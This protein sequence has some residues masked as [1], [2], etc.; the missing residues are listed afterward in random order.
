MRFQSRRSILAAAPL[1]LSL[2]I[3][4]SAASGANPE[5]PDT[6]GDVGSSSS[7]VLDADGNPVVS[8]S[9]STN[10]DLKVLHCND[11]NC[12]GGDES[13][14]SPDTTGNDGYYTSLELDAVGNP[15]ISYLGGAVDLKVMHCNDPNCAGGDESIVS[16]DTVGN[17][18]YY[19][20]LELDADGN[21]VVSYYD[22]TNGNLKVLH[23]NDPDCVGGDSIAIA[24]SGGNFGADVVGTHTSLALDATGKPVISYHD[25]TNGDLKVVHCDDPACQDGQSQNA[26]RA[27]TAD[28]VG[29]Y[30]SLELD[31]DGNPVVS[32][33]D[34][35]NGDLKLLHCYDPACATGGTV[36]RVDLIDRVGLWTSLALDGAGKPVISYFDA[37]N[38]AL[39]VV[40]CD[41]ASCADGQLDE[42]VDNAGDV[43]SWSSLVLDTDGNPVISYY[44]ATNDLNGDLKALHCDNPTCAAS[45]PVTDIDGDGIP[46]NLDSDA[47][48]GSA[49]P[50]FSDMSTT[51]PTTATVLSGSVTVVDASDPAK[52]VRVTAGPGGAVLSPVCGSSTAV[53]FEPSDS[54]T[55][56]C[57]SIEIQDVS[58][59]P[60]AV[61]VSGGAVVTFPDGT[62]GTVDSTP[63]GSAVVTGVS[64]DGVTLT[65]GGLTTPVAEGGS[66]NLIVG[67][68]GNNT[69]NGTAG[70]DMIVGKSGND[71]IN[72]NGGNDTIDAGAGNNTI[73]GGAGNDKIDTGNDNDT[74]NGGA[75]D[76]QIT[77]GAG[78]DKI[79]GG[80]GFDTCQPG[81][82]NNKVKNCE[83]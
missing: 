49:P 51:V 21:P 44:D 4:A 61:T 10:N 68:S 2:C 3:T 24:D 57:H 38:S 73:N 33:Y 76:D 14:E 36:E 43:G 46:D 40:H 52:G 53:E 13:I 35:T 64:G 34:V 16:P 8:Y 71:T 54:A 75:D 32:Y 1:A 28:L 6:V 74:V 23:C 48:S 66:L 31:G 11:P 45:P 72:G 83:A 7:L 69:L 22:Q 41:I 29:Y 30:T 19:T 65:V 70:D 56:T 59:G 5:S 18:G 20:S 77:T 55:I 37:T 81:S 82:G 12:A 60:V 26:Y 80:S 78:N 58:G 67:S 63:S 79:E 15:V 9:D 50:G 62:S 42:I 25:V 47:G 17:V 39:K 27:D